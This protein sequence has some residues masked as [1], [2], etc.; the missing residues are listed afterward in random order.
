MADNFYDAPEPSGPRLSSRALAR[1]KAR[2]KWRIAEGKRLY[3][4][5]SNRERMRMTAGM[6]MPSKFIRALMERPTN[7]KE[8]SRG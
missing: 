7:E 3:S 1:K 4:G 5:L 8:G 2:H 6:P